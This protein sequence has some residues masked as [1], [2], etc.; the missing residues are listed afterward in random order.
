MIL[1][2]VLP[3]KVFFLEELVVELKKHNCTYVILEYNVS[4]LIQ[5]VSIFRGEALL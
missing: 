4:Y 2:R 5:N 1:A 3:S